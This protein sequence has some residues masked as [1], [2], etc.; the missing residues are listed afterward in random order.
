M[1]TSGERERERERERESEWEK[2]D[3]EKVE[4]PK[5]LH[6]RRTQNFGILLHKSEQLIEILPI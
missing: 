5:L 6:K 1:L 3:E 4:Y 2:I